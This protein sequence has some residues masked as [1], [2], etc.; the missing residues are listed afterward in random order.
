MDESPVML[1]Q[2][3]TQLIIIRQHMAVDLRFRVG[4]GLLEQFKVLQAPR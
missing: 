2:R 3:Q 4:T 1:I